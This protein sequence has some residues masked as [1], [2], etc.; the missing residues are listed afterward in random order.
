VAIK[1]DFIPLFTRIG[2][3]YNSRLDIATMARFNRRQVITI[4]S[5]LYLA[6]LTALAAY[7]LRQANYYSLPIPNALGALTV[8]L[9]PLA[10]I[11]LES[12]I[13]FQ[14][15]LVAKGQLSHSKVYQTVNAAFLV[16]EAVLA[17]LSGSHIA[18]VGGLFCPLHDKWTE[19][20]K[21]RNAK[22]IQAIQ[23]AF[24]CCGFNGLRDMAYPFPDKTHGDDRCIVMYERDTICVNPWRDMER[25]VAIIMLVVP[26][27]V[28][29]WKTVL[30]FS[31]GVEGSWLPSA[32]RLPNEAAD[33]ANG[34]P[35]PAITFRDVEEGEA[36]S[37]R[38]EISRLNTD[39]NL[40]TH[41]EAGR[42]RPSP[43][44]QE[45][46]NNMWSRDD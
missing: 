14:S 41:V 20:R 3:S 38:A 4:S 18:P 25:H 44:I 35:R 19:M 2:K 27:A 7:A 28:F 24:N 36:D 26:L 15:H 45:A 33:S 6:A 39:S 17:T 12:I 5:A 37:L 13:S 46:E 23:D 9:P 1:I 31:P 21:A 34:R 29:L 30:F 40:A 10:G 11:A 8:A 22:A 42:V 32:I 16:Y 43:L